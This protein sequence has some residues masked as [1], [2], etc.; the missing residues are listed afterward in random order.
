[1]LKFTL[2]LT[3]FALVL[4]TTARADLA[5]P[6]YR[7]KNA[8]LELCKETERV[9]KQATRLASDYF[10]ADEQEK[11]A[12]L[13]RARDSLLASYQ[14]DMG[15]AALIAEYKAYIEQLR[16]RCAAIDARYERLKKK[17]EGNVVEH[18][19]V[20]LAWLK[21][22]REAGCSEIPQQ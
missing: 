17:H 3:L 11:A 13:T 12:G 5:K 18:A 16:A 21:E 10:L 19:N 2:A 4:T 20:T 7:L 9:I 8:N 1:M 22:S 14:G 6:E 15:C